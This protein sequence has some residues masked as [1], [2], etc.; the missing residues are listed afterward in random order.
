VQTVIRYYDAGELVGA[1]MSP[2]S[3]RSR[4][5]RLLRFQ[6]SDVDRLEERRARG[7]RGRPSS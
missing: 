1:D 5:R 6:D 7:L 2:V 4:K 3:E